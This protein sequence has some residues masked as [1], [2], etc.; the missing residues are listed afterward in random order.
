MGSFEKFMAVSG[1]LTFVIAIA[2]AIY[3]E[4]IV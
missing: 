1:I 2:I 3:L 4:Y